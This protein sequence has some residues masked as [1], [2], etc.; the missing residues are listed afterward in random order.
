[1]RPPDVVPR[2]RLV[3]PD[4]PPEYAAIYGTFAGLCASEGAMRVRRLDDERF[5]DLY[6]AHRD[7]LFRLAILICGDA[8]RS[9][10][11][12]AEVFAKVLPRWRGSTVVG[13]PQRYLRRALVNE[14]TGGFRRRA[15]ER[16]VAAKRWGDDRGE[17][18]M[19]ADVDA[20]DQMRAALACL[21][22]EQRAVLVLRY[23]ADLTEAEI[24]E[25]LKVSPG[26]V[27]SRASRAMARLRELLHDEEAIDA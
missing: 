27:K 1:M 10:D 21:P 9:E 8:T 22:T 16:R 20:R 2:T 6:T 25:L 15:I 4:A 19:E 24:A 23:Y 11:A 12:V 5:D 26:T 17:L 7:G 18:R 3:R 14:L 13:D